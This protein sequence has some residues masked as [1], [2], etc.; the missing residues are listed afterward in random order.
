MENPSLLHKEIIGTRGTNS[1]ANYDPKAFNYYAPLDALAFPLDL[2]VG[3]TS[4]PQIGEYEF[5]GLYLYNVT[6]D[7]GFEYLGRISS[8]DEVTGDYCW[9]YSGFTR[10]VFIDNHVYSVTDRSVKA[11]SLDDLSVIVGEDEYENAEALENNCIWWEDTFIDM[12]PVGG[13]IQ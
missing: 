5:S 1:E 4:G 3:E 8:T 13:G 9:I 10:G 6:V 2:Y 11:A 12:L 7:N